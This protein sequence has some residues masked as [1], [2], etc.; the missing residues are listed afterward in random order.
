MRRSSAIRHLLATLESRA[1]VPVLLKLNDCEKLVF[2]QDS[3]QEKHTQA[4]RCQDMR[5]LRLRRLF[6]GIRRPL[7]PWDNNI[8]F[9]LLRGVT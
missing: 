5:T 1:L 9:F 3:S 6:S 2:L 7:R 4:F 8:R